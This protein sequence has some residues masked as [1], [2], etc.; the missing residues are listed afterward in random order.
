M[1]QVAT[2]VDTLLWMRV[3]QE[4]W[5][6]TLDPQGEGHRLQAQRLN[7]L[8]DMSRRESPLYVRRSARARRLS[9]FEPISKAELMRH[10]DDW[11]TDRRLNLDT[12]HRL[13]AA[14]GVT[15]PSDGEALSQYLVWTSS[16][17]TGLPGIFVQDKLSLAA[18]DALEQLRLRGGDPLGSALPWWGLGRRFAYVG[19]IGGPY[20][21]CVNVERLRRSMPFWCAP[22]VHLLS[23]LEPMAQLARQLQ[24]LQPSV[25]ITYPSCA[26]ALAAHQLAGQLRLRLDEVWCGGEQLSA[27]QRAVIETAFG[28]TVRNS[29]G[30]SEFYSMAFGCS[31]GRLHLNDD[32]LIL[33]P[34]D[35][36]R[37][38]VPVGEFSDL[39]LLTNLANLSQPLVRY[40]LSDRVRFDPEPCPC[41][42][43]FPVIEVQGR[44]DDV[45]ALPAADSAQP[46]A[47]PAHGAGQDKAHTVTLLP[48]V[49]ETLIEE[50]AGLTGFQLLRQSGNTLELRLPS[51][52]GR[53]STQLQAM[54]NRCQQVLHKALAEH[55]S[56]PMTLRYSPQPPVQQ[57]GSGKL[58]RVID[59]TTTA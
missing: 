36:Q 4:T 46:A 58:R 59:L 47:T 2:P 12:V 6:A 43:Q 52:P 53:S 25:L 20:A 18:F 16:G 39:T 24:D 29:Y 27:A 19:A 50:G 23:V 13:L 45:L 40:E 56:A 51:D 42:N 28:C 38:P 17:T 14:D 10:F 9:D 26:Q 31:H 5:R 11:A 3:W 54:V 34:V 32:W 1:P 37:R 7:T 21:G 49:I 33:E 35:V 41:G 44:S 57:P 55:G 22:D 48:L 30:A 8:L 15:P